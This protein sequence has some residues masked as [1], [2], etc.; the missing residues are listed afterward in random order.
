MTTQSAT[1]EEFETNKDSI[2][3]S[4]YQEL[5]FKL[6]GQISDLQAR[7]ERDVLFQQQRL[8]TPHPHGLKVLNDAAFKVCKTN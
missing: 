2:R 7:S 1:N 4:V 6:I 8:A 3:R 5:I